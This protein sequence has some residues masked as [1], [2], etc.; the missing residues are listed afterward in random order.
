MD[1]RMPGIDGLET[2]RRIRQRLA[3]RPLRIVALTANAID[4]DRADCM[5][6]GMD[7][8]ITKPVK[9]SELRRLLE[10]WL[11]PSPPKP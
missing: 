8:F 2:T 6:A 7:D 1:L 4:E 11:K 3:G 9:Q 10:M 5:A